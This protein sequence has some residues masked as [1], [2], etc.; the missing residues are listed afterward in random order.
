MTS[1]RISRAYQKMLSAKSLRWK[2]AWADGF[3]AAVSAQNART[4]V[5]LVRSPAVLRDGHAGVRQ[6]GCVPVAAASRWNATTDVIGMVE[7]T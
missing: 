7:G 5:G 3:I 2:R 4:M 1:T 6:E